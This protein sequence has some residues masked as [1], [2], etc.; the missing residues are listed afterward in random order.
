MPAIRGVDSCK[1]P[2]N[3]FGYKQMTIPSLSE[4]GGHGILT[5]NVAEL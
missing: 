5:D 4:Q 2:L 1:A 3:R